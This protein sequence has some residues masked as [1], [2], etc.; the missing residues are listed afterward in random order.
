MYFNISLF[1]SIFQV[2]FGAS[3]QHQDTTANEGNGHG[4]TTVASIWHHFLIYN[5]VPTGV[6]GVRSDVRRDS[7]LSYLSA[8]H[9]H[10][11]FIRLLNQ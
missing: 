8:I 10:H 2:I 11:I 4:E 1:Q 7:L 3:V 6:S 9:V 5:I